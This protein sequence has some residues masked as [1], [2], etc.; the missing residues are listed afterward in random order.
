M[1]ESRTVR[2]AVGVMSLAL[3]ATTATAA[4]WHQFRGPDRL[5]KTEV[6]GLLTSWDEGQPREVW[7]KAIGS[8]YSAVSVVGDRLYTMAADGDDE[9]VLCLDAASG[10]VVWKTSVGAGKEELFPEGGPRSTPTIDGDLVFAASSNAHLVALSVKDGS[11][12]WR[13]DLAELGPAPRFGYSVSPSRGPG[14]GHRRG[15]QAGRRARS[16]G[17]PP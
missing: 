14:P 2:L 11:V 13:Q 1:Q 7:R 4:D 8:G 12:R 16:G 5:G 3:A 9:V 6:R 10:E 15:R 17:L